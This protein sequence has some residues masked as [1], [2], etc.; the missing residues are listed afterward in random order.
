M[1]A[2]AAPPTI[3][4]GL[5]P[6][7][8][9]I[10]DVTPSPRNPR[11]GDIGAISESL[12]RFGQ[13]KPIVV[14]KSTGHVVAGNHLY[15]AALALGWTQIAANVVDMDDRQAQAYMVADNRTAD[16][17]SYDE[18]ILT[19]LLRELAVDGDLA[20]TGYDGED[21]DEMLAKLEWKAS[22]GSTVIQYILIFE[23]EEQQLVW[24]Q[25]LKAL[26]KRYADDPNATHA[27]RIVR[28]ILEAAAGED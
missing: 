17:G 9:P 4:P 16:L 1:S 28:A 23:D 20:G 26:R 6:L 25:W 7:V 22:G 2:D 19:E 15:R 12:R 14:Q 27:A 5:A 21:V 11:Q 10:T 8:I 18:A 13:Q 3:A 24:N